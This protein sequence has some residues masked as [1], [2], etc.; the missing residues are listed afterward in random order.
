MYIYIYTCVIYIYPLIAGTAFLSKMKTFFNF[1]TKTMPHIM[2]WIVMVLLGGTNQQGPYLLQ[3]KIISQHHSITARAARVILNCNSYFH[4]LILNCGSYS[5][6]SRHSLS[7]S[8]VCSSLRLQMIISF[9][10]N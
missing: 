6:S 2:S 7:Q 9:E 1:V 5:N 4:R 10:H 3:P 8:Y